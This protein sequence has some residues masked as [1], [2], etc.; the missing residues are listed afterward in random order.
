MLKTTTSTAPPLSQRSRKVEGIFAPKKSPVICNW[1]CLSSRQ[2]NKTF[3]LSFTLK[4]YFLQPRIRKTI[5]KVPTFWTIVTNH[6]TCT[7]EMSG[8][9]VVALVPTSTSAS[10][11]L[12]FVWFIVWSRGIRCSYWDHEQKKRKVFVTHSLLDKVWDYPKLSRF[13]MSHKF[14]SNWLYSCEYITGI[15]IWMLLYSSDSQPCI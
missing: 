13:H 1:I 8:T 14:K 15:S 4:G 9:Q 3:R 6:W 7:T 10:I 2:N 5:L 11:T 12:I